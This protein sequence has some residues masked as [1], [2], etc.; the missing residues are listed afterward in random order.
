M[1]VVRLCYWLVYLL[2]SVAIRHGYV[3][4]TFTDHHHILNT[5][6]YHTMTDKEIKYHAQ[7]QRTLVEI[8]KHID[9]TLAWMDE[10]AIIEE[11]HLTPSQWMSVLNVQAIEEE[12]L[13]D[14]EQRRAYSMIQWEEDHES[15]ADST[16]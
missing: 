14:P 8:Y 12:W 5:I 15:D 13:L 3:T 6:S 9:K 2:L 7:L 4:D 11:E 1:L 10:G 16:D